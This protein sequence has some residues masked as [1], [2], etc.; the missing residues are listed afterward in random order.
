MKIEIVRKEFTK[1]ST[2]GELFIDDEFF[3]YT[4][5][6][7]VREVKIPRET[8]IPYGHYEVITN[9][10]VRFKRVMPLILNVPGYSGV[11][12][13]SGNTSAN[14]EGCPLVGFTKDIDFVGQSKKAFSVFMKRLHAGLTEG[15]VYLTITKGVDHVQKQS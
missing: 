6:D 14:T 5:E 11:R 4:L 13:H 9:Y 12:I 7:V 1:F 10:S 15:R 8:A 3:C 2:I